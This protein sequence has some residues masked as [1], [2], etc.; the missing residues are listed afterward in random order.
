[1]F[2]KKYFQL[3]IEDSLIQLVLK[4]TYNTV[5]WGICKK[6]EIYHWRILNGIATIVG[7][8]FTS[9]SNLKFGMD[10]QT[11]CIF[12]F[13]NS[14]RPKHAI[15]RIWYK[16]FLIFCIEYIR[17]WYWNSKY[18]NRCLNLHKICEMKSDIPQ[19][20]AWCLVCLDLFV[21]IN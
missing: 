19:S 12:V 2:K 14:Q 15:V 4:V 18:I 21:G 11:V 8:F 20:S 6:I 9:Q 7:I 1:M 13:T 3:S 5:W 17:E 16:Y 10:G